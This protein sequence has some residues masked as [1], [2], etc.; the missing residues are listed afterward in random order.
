[1]HKKYSQ[2]M[3]KFTKEIIHEKINSVNIDK[4]ENV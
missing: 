4:N 1:M 3:C 2:I